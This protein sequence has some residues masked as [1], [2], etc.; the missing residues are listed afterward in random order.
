MTDAATKAAKK[1]EDK[2]ATPKEAAE[3][4][5]SAAI[6]VMNS[7]ITTSTD[8][9]QVCLV[10][11]MRKNLPVF[12]VRI[13]S[14]HSSTHQSQA[15]SMFPSVLFVCVCKSRRFELA[16]AAARKQESIRLYLRWMQFQNKQKVRTEC[17]PSFSLFGSASRVSS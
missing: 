5:T 8:L 16:S 1:A 4:A 14:A 6:K 12:R 3:A 2:K 10:P 9:T 17:A 13:W 11:G 7:W 15:L